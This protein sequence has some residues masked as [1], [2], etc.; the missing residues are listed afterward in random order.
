MAHPDPLTPSLQAAI[1][2]ELR[3]LRHELERLAELLVGDPHFAAHY[4]DQLQRFDLLG[5]FAE[6]SAGVLD[7]LA[8]GADAATAVAG[9]RVGSIQARLLAALPPAVAA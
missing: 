4:C 3:Q 1:A 6:E 5:Q 2:T 9:V 8:A 7:R